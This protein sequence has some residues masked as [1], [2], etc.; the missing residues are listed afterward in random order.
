MV[1]EMYME[2]VNNKNNQEQNGLDQENIVPNNEVVGS[3]SSVP[4]EQLPISSNIIQDASP[5]EISTSTISTSPMG[6]G[7]GGGSIPAQAAAGSLECKL[8]FSNAI[9]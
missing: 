1:E 8:I 2:E 4:E 3:K 7:D 9:F 6:G 5:K